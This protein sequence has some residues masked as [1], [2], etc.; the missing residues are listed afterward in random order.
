MLL[1]SFQFLERRLLAAAGAL[2]L[3]LPASAAFAQAS[4]SVTNITTTTAT[5]TPS[6][7]S[8]T[9]YLGVDNGST[10]SCTSQSGN[11]AVSL[12]SLTPGTRHTVTAWPA[13][14]SNCE[15]PPSLTLAHA[16]FTTLS[17]PSLTAGSVTKDG[18]TLTIANHSG[19]WYY[20][21]TSPTGGQCSSNAV[22]GTSTT[23][24]GL[25]T[26]TTYTFKAYSDSQCS[27]ELATAS[28][29]TTK[30]NKV[31]GLTVTSG[32]ESLSLSWDA[33]TG[34]TSYR[35]Q[36]KSSGQGYGGVNQ[37][38]PTSNSH[39][40]SS[41]NNGTQ[42]T[43]RVRATT[44]GGDGEWSD[45]VTGTPAAVLTFTAD[46]ITFTEARLRLQNHTG[47]WYLDGGE[48]STII[49]DCVAVAGTSHWLTT[50][51]AA[52]NYSF[53]AYSASDCAEASKLK[54]VTFRTESGKVTGL[55]AT[56]GNNAS[57]DLSWFKVIS[58]TGYK[59]QWKSGAQDWSSTRQVTSTTISHKLTK[60]TVTVNTA[61]TIR[62]AATSSSSDGA[63]SD[64]VVATPVNATLRADGVGADS[65]TLTI[66]NHTGT[67]YHKRITPTAGTCS[68]GVSTTSTTAS[69]L[70]PG[71]THTFS[72][73]ADNQCTGDVLATTPPFLTK[74]GKAA[75]VTATAANGALD[76]A[77]R[78]VTGASSY[79]VQWKSSSD[80]GWD[81]TSRQIT[82]TKA[83]TAITGLTNG[84]QYTIRVAGTTAAGDGSWS[85]NATGTPSASAVTLTGS[86]TASGGA[87]TLANH[88]GDWW[89]RITP[90]AAGNCNSGPSGGTFVDSTLNSGA[91]YTLT[92]YGNSSCTSKLTSLDFLTLPGKVTGVTLA[93][94]GASLDVS[95]TAV[96]GAAS[97]KVQW[98][99]GMESFGSAREVNYTGAL[100]TLSGL[101]NGTPYSVRVAAVNASGD[102]AWSDTATATPSVTLTATNVTSTGAKLT[103]AGITGTAYLSGRGGGSYSLACTA[104]SGGTH[105]PTLQGNTTYEF[106]AYSNSGCTGTAL[107][108]TSFATPGAVTLFADN[109]KQ[110]SVILYLKGW[111][112]LPGTRVSFVVHEAGSSMP[113]RQCNAD[114][115]PRGHTPYTGLKPGTTYIAR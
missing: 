26:G 43:V 17:E 112:T 55:T 96:T 53:S 38:T 77:W 36:W 65:A 44:G 10:T 89:Y 3:L 14:V 40:I 30:P 106:N 114:G 41:L 81:A 94:Q 92:A 37:A 78:A 7:L 84:T 104:A 24:T 6:G 28:D 39:T 63:W 20:K 9:W 50:L 32:N 75:G 16:N 46:G 80:S 52:T 101:T 100:L 98:K 54:S 12:A 91:E 48:G 102:G 68:S 60:N 76:V 85:D 115:R 11:S 42:Y 64:E 109:I 62:V 51:T 107:A 22:S 82:T 45:E 90:P 49:A 18:A 5:V 4:F 88:S 34:A 95:W 83:S 21:Y 87:F 103:V 13:S 8:G 33:E 108:S 105:S 31:T 97:Y 19:N 56:A 86:V 79:K 74:L 99:S 47:T 113:H 23:L 71:L 27:V 73:Y 111:E 58:A 59:V 57:I 67:W 72:A 2:A 69:N 29:F 110:N 35:V 70:S 25:D 15:G 61:Y 66:S 93:N 1:N